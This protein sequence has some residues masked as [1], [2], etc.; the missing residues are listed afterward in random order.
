MNSEDRIFVKLDVMER[1]MSGM[2]A[3]IR[4]LKI[5]QKTNNNRLTNVEEQQS[6]SEARWWK[7]FFI[8]VAAAGTG[9]AAVAIKV[10]AGD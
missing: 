6:K 9:F 5:F 3:D 10:F 7:V 2:R 1:H 8:V 4:E